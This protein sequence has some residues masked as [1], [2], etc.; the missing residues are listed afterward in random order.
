MSIYCECYHIFRWKK[1][2]KTKS[3]LLWWRHFA[4][5]SF[6][7]LKI[8]QGNCKRF[9][10]FYCGL[11]PLALPLYELYWIKINSKQPGCGGGGQCTWQSRHP[12]SSDFIFEDGNSIHHPMVNI[13]IFSTLSHS[14]QSL[15]KQ[16]HSLSHCLIQ[17]SDVV[18]LGVI[19][20]LSK[21]SLSSTRAVNDKMPS[22]DKPALRDSG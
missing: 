5:R 15:V 20:L 16:I 13:P 10:G 9:V 4:V 7:C 14:T 8:Y 12:S 21:S 3:R 6:P 1:V 11:V 2:F 18:M 19:L 22:C 17:G